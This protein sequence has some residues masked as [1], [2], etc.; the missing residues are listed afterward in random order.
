MKGDAFPDGFRLHGKE[1]MLA[2]R[3]VQSRDAA[4][5]W[6]ALAF[7]EG[8]ALWR[9]SS[10]I[11]QDSAKAGD[12]ARPATLAWLAAVGVPVAEIQLHGLG[13]ASDRAKAEFWRHERLP[14]PHQ[15][16]EHPE[17][18]Y[19][20]LSAALSL[21]ED[22]GSLLSARGP[23]RE[24]ATAL[25]GAGGDAHQFLKA[26]GADRLYW[27][28]LDEPF[29]RFLARLPEDLTQYDDGGAEYGVGELRLWAA[30]V[31]HAAREAFRIAT[32]ALQT[33]G[34]TLQAVARSEDAFERRLAGLVRPYLKEEVSV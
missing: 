26:L 9:D 14:L 12:Q 17:D 22:A 27:A 1:P 24:I 8:R 28:A 5:P 13:L 18:L 15:F 34:R 25:I 20:P 11:L 33:S 30:A 32:G 7:S 23:L 10:V 21:A 4:D 6:P 16:V 3:R 29:L 31:R 19:E 2:F